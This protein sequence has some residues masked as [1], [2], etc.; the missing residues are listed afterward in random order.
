M[1]F[2]NTAMGAI[3]VVPGAEV[4]ISGSPP[5][6]IMMP[7]KQMTYGSAASPAAPG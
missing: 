7:L 5:D 3:R 2:G 4:T 1:G 6:S